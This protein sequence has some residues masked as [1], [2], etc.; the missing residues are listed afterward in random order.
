MQAQ[1]LSH[2]AA[3][4]ATLAFLAG[5]GGS[6]PPVGATGAMSQ[7]LAIAQ[8]AA[9]GK[10]WM[11]PEV[12]GKTL[13]YAA[14]S[15]ESV[16]VF[17]YPKGKPV[18]KLDGLLTVGGLCSDSSGDV[19][20][21]T[22]FTSSS[23]IVYEF[24]HGGTS[25]IASLNDPG[26]ATSC[27]VD[28][29][30][31]NLAVANGANVAVYEHAQG[32]P[33]LYAADDVPAE[34]CDYDNSGNLFID[35]SAQDSKIA[36]LPAGGTVFTDISL[37]QSFRPLS[38]QWDTDH[39]VIAGL[40]GGPIGEEPIYTVKM[41]GSIGTV[42]GPVMFWSRNNKNPNYP[43]QFLLDGTTLIGPGR[44]DVGLPLI[45]LW[46]YPEGGKPYKTI[47]YTP[48]NFAGLALSSASSHR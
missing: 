39:F 19:F 7:S 8:R 28:P 43:V 21:P 40:L 26:F 17:E 45:N 23:S 6:Q 2:F 38:L 20:I 48:G 25:P 44:H 42:G 10:S 47:R 15:N 27:S 14:R 24:A 35:G 3:L 16:I 1:R 34:Y 29:V 22:L 33:I 5:C 13:L 41:T 46:S 37:S 12:K 36:D 32:E 30:T 4:C 31:G 9:R 18:G 11:L